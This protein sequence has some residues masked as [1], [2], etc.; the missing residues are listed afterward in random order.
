MLTT[1]ADIRQ[2]VASFDIVKP[3]VWS[4]ILPIDFKTMYELGNKKSPKG[5]YKSVFTD[6]GI[7]HY[8]IDING[9]DGAVPLDLRVA[10]D[11]PSRDMVTNIG[12]S[13]HVHPNQEMCFRNIHNLSHDRMVHWVPYAQTMPE[14]AIYGYELGFFEELAAINDYKVEKLYIVNRVETRYVA[15]ASFRKTSDAPFRWRRNKVHAKTRIGSK[16]VWE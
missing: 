8:S 1:I 7:D 4:L 9:Q 2:K 13:E 3:D 16:W 12:T 11:L 15:C 10:I 6:M 5:T 14:H